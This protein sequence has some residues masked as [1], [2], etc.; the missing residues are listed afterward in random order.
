MNTHAWLIDLVAQY[1]YLVYGIIVI[2]SCLEGPILALIC[3][4]LLKLDYFSFAPLYVALMVGDLLGDIIWY[5]IGYHFGHRFVTK[6]GKYF[7][8][9]EIEVAIVERIFHQHKHFILF[10]SKISNGF[11]FALATLFT[12]GMVKIPFKLYLS[13][14]L[15]GQFIWSGLLIGIGYFFSHVYTSVDNI[16]GKMSVVALFIFLVIIFVGFTRYTK[17]KYD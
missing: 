7:S 11:G 1:P 15:L 6:Y 17:K 12:A 14:N 8:V 3:G 10:I 13:I 16:F 5:G 4:L 9:T 2:I